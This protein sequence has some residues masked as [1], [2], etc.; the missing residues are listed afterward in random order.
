[1]RNV[2]LKFFR[3]KMFNVHSRSEAL[4]TICAC[5]FRDGYHAEIVHSP[6]VADAVSAA[7]IGGERRFQRS[8]QMCESPRHTVRA[9]TGAPPTRRPAARL[10]TVGPFRRRN[11][12][13]CVRGRIRGTPPAAHCPPSLLSFP[14]WTTVPLRKSY[15]RTHCKHQVFKHTVL[16]RNLSTQSR[17]VFKFESS[18]SSMRAITCSE[19]F[20]DTPNRCP[21]RAC[22]PRRSAHPHRTVH[23]R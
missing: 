5:I 16:L 2:S 22:I 7:R 6:S 18:P 17:K 4:C 15:Q 14:L 12:L 8:K 21:E 11:A 3:S 23:T 9:S 20:F 13:R 1:M 19:C 10:I